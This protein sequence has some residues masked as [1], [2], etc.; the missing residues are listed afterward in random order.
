MKLK[1]KDCMVDLETLGTV[2]GCQVLSI[3]AC[4]FSRHSLKLG[5]EFNVLV[6]TRTQAK[7]GLEASKSTLDW[8]KTQPP[9]AQGLLKA[10]KGPGALRLPL[11]LQ[12]FGLWIMANG[13]PE[14]LIW[15]K[16]ADFDIP[17]LVVAYARQG[18]CF[19]TLVEEAASVPEPK[20]AGVQHD[21]LDDAK[22]Q[23]RWAV[24]IY[25]S[26]AAAKAA[27]RRGI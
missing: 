24:K 26:L 2:P 19:R 6:N 25:Q 23:A 21:A 15:S 3:G 9:E 18:R 1:M 16:G 5:A 7:H 13:G 17:I 27:K 8:W 20:R 11:A 4:M 12:S 22:H 10:C 14:V